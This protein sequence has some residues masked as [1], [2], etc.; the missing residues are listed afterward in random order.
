[1]RPAVISTIESRKRVRSRVRGTNAPPEL[2][3]KVWGSDSGE[4]A[5]RSQR[6]NL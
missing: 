4:E 6:T 1:V 2:L 5:K 3:G